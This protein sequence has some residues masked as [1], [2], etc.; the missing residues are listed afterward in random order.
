MPLGGD[1]LAQER[2]WLWY[3]K[4][5]QYRNPSSCS[6]KP[7]TLDSPQATPIHTALPPLQPR[8]NDCKQNFVLWPFKGFLCLQQAPP[9]LGGQKSPT[10]HSQML[11]GHLFLALELWAPEPD[12]GL[13]LHASLEEP[14]ATEISVTSATAGGSRT[15]PFHVST[16]PTSREVASSASPWL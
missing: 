3:Q 1:C 10:F 15:S 14:P 4:I 11:C 8:V 9:L 13:R 16:L 6:P 7:Q 5:T 12:L 2:W